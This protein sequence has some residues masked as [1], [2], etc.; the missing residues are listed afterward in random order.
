MALNKNM[1]NKA[2]A[3]IKLNETRDLLRDTN[4][5]VIFKQNKTFKQIQH[6]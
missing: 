1:S 2:E 3:Q 5:D 4:K 6:I